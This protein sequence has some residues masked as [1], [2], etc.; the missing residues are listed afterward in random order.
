VSEDE[1]VISPAR[2]IELT[3]GQRL[4]TTVPLVATWTLRDLRVRYRQSLLGS[5]WSLVQPLT[6]LVTYGWVLTAVLDV[7]R[8]EVPYLTFA[9]AGMVPFTFFSQALGQGVGSIQ[10]SGPI[11]SRL[12]FPREVLPL[13][14]VGGALADLAIMTATLVAASW[15]QVA[16]PD[17]HLLGLVLVYAVLVAW[18]SAIT[19][20]AAAVTVFRRD[21]NFAVPLALRVLFIGTPVMYPASLIAE[22]APW[23]NRINPLTVVIEG[24]R[25]CLYRGAWPDLTLLGAHAAAGCALL[26]GAFVLLRRLEPRMTDHV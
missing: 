6:I 22:S 16:T 12:Y 8:E 25:T 4:R 20:V 18:T 13:S 24:T 1:V 26:A 23:L 2:G 9:W 14:V 10:Q 7:R 5:A 19:L 15:I 11:I 17:V 3:V 21:L